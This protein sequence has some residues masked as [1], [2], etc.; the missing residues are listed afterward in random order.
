MGLMLHRYGSQAERSRNR[1]PDC[2]RYTLRLNGENAVT[3]MIDG[4]FRIQMTDDAL[5]FID[6]A[7]A[8][9]V[10]RVARGVLREFS[11]EVG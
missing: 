6:T 7:G 2:I 8:G 9:V 3:S 5:E 1:I 11:A 4:R 10:M